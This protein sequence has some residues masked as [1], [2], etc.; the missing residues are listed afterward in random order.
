MAPPVAPQTGP[1]GLRLSSQ[2]LWDDLVVGEVHPGGAHDVRRAEAMTCS[3]SSK[4]E[5]L[6]TTATGD[7]Q[8]LLHL[9]GPV[10]VEQP[11]PQVGGQGVDAR[12]VVDDAP[13]IRG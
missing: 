12:V 13:G 6:P 1:G 4:V 8:P 10:H 7:V 3:A 5:K 9:P 2:G 11:G